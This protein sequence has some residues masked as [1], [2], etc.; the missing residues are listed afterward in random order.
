[1]G[2]FFPEIA[3]F[4]QNSGYLSN[5]NTKHMK[6]FTLLLMAMCISLVSSAQRPMLTSHSPTTGASQ[7]L[8]SVHITLSF[9]KPIVKGSG[10]I[11]LR[12]RTLK[13][14]KTI[15]ASSS[16]VSVSGSF[17]TVSNLGL[18]S[19]CYYHITFDS[20]AFDSAS[21]HSTGLYDTSTWWFRTGGIG[22]GVGTASNPFLSVSLVR[23]VANGLP[24]ICCTIPQAATLTLRVHD[25]SGRQVLIRSFAAV[26]GYNE[27]PLET[28]LPPGTYTV[29]VNDGRSY[30]WL[31]ATLQ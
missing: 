11:Y 18:I 13:S 28:S 30:S 10:N 14:T 6:N 26:P 17:V 15:A 12:N 20:T 2:D 19:G 7:V 5:H 31:K 3:A 4:S 23:N 27:L 9:N 22:V 8:T 16:D 21:Y 1:L 29:V 25:M 24:A